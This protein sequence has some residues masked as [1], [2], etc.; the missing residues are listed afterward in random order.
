MNLSLNIKRNTAIKIAIAAWIWALTT[1]FIQK[2]FV[3]DRSFDMYDWAA[4]TF[5]I[6]IAYTWCRL[7][8]L[9]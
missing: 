1:E 2:F 7:K 8:Y 6:L 9:K 5:G 4:D 3:P